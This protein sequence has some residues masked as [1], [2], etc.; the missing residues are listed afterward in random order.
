MDQK[1]RE[2]TIKTDVGGDSFVIA[3]IPADKVS[4]QLLGKS[5]QLVRTVFH[6]AARIPP[7]AVVHGETSDRVWLV[8]PRGRVEPRSITVGEITDE[9]AIVIQGLDSGDIV[10]SEPHPALSAGALIAVDTPQ[11]FPTKTP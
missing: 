7:R 9:E 6:N 11:P 5:V 4:G 2:C 3:E 10:V 1:V 8:S